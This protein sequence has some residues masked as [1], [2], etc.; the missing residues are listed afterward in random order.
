[1]FRAHAI[2]AFGLLHDPHAL[3]ILPFPVLAGLF[4][5]ALGLCFTGL[6]PAIGI[7]LM[8]RRLVK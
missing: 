1:M 6:V 4:F 8:R 2:S 3:L 7:H 5:A